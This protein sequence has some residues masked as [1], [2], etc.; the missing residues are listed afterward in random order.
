MR[1]NGRKNKLAYSFLEVFLSLSIFC[2]LLGIVFAFPVK[3]LNKIN[4]V[5]RQQEDF[6]G[7]YEK[8]SLYMQ[9]ATSVSLNDGMLTLRLHSGPKAKTLNV[10]FADKKRERKRNVMDCCLP[11]G[12]RMEWYY[13]D[14]ENSEWKKL[15]FNET[16]TDLRFLKVI[17]FN[18]NG[19]V[20]EQFVF[21]CYAMR[22]NVAVK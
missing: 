14:G 13:E 6:M 21:S 9:K 4:S 8:V 15:L 5:Q 10:L 2:V 17:F 7:F 18:A 3:V 19:K 16:Y 20:L 12:V 1:K 22:G 11:V